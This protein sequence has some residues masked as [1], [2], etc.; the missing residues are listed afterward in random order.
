MSDALGER[1]TKN[2]FRSLLRQRFESQLAQNEISV[3]ANA[4]VSNAQKS[5]IYCRK[6]VDVANFYGCTTKLAQLQ[7]WIVCDRCP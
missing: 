6:A 1:V 7:D 4:N 5:H 3:T 2:N